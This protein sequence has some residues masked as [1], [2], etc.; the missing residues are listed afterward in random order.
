MSRPHVGLPSLGFQCWKEESLQNLVVKIVE[1]VAEWGQRAVKD[2]CLELQVDSLWALVLGQWLIGHQGNTGGTEL[3][4]FRVRARG[5]AFFQ[6]EVLVE[7][8][9]SLLGSLPN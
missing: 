4:G 1:I 9:I 8:T 6:T 2:L 3:S 7:A 5:A